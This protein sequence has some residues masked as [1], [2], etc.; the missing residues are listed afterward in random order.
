VN[1][2]MENKGSG[3]P[4]DKAKGKIPSTGA[5]RRLREL[6]TIYSHASL[7]ERL[8]TAFT[9]ILA[10]MAIIQG[11]LFY[12]QIGAIH[13]D[14]R[15]WINASLKTPSV[16]GRSFLESTLIQVDSG[17]APARDGIVEYE[18][19]FSK[20][21]N[22]PILDFPP[23]KKP[24]LRSG[25]IY[26]NDPVSAVII[27]YDWDTWDKHVITDEEATDF[28]NGEIFL[29]TY[30]VITYKDFSGI[31]HIQHFCNWSYSS[32][33]IGKKTGMTAQACTDYNDVDEN[34]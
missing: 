32:S 13:I 29:V 16:V 26:P 24:S 25:V 1:G 9:G 4:A 3:N 28:A 17:K 6:K 18:I 15:P 12:Q 34:K 21:G 14:Q 23:N 11:A 5:L 7:T 19:K 20:N 22:E 27:M 2:E 8:L 33:A 30:G 31:K 10:V